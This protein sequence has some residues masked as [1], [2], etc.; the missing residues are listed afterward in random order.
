MER[1][2][3]LKRKIEDLRNENKDLKKKLD[4][5]NIELGKQ[6]SERIKQTILHGSSY[7]KFKPEVYNADTEIRGTNP[8]SNESK[9]SF[10]SIN[11][12]EERKRDLPSIEELKYNNKFKEIESSLNVHDTALDVFNETISK[13][14]KMIAKIEFK[15][16]LAGLIPAF[17][18]IAIQI[19][20]WKTNS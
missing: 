19:L 13:H 10:H 18:I 20:I 4:E 6:L 5:A 2:I 7:F 8:L 1:N 14:E 16:L 3:R 11:D 17:L 12:E 9:Y 15:T